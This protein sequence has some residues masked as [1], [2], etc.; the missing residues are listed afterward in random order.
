MYKIAVKRRGPGGEALSARLPTVPIKPR[1]SDSGV[2]RVRVS[3]AA[4]LHTVCAVHLNVHFPSQYLHS[5]MHIGSW[6]RD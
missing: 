4:I 5:T 3:P 6:E 1:R 2:N